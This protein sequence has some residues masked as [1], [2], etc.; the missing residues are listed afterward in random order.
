MARAARHARRALERRLAPWWA[1]TPSETARPAG[2]SGDCG[3]LLTDIHAGP[4]GATSLEPDER[5]GLIPTCIA[6][7]DDLNAAEQANIADA[8][9]GMRR[10]RLTT[11]RF[12]DGMFVRSLHGAMYGDVWKWATTARPARVRQ[13]PVLTTQLSPEAHSVPG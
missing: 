1:L 11:V 5:D 12:V 8:V 13:D 2:G 9:L 3:A 10:R 6:T 7:R 4:D